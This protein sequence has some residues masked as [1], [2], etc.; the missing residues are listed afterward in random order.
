MINI[1]SIKGLV[2]LNTS[3]VTDMNEM[4][5]DCAK[6]KDLNLVYF[7]THKVTTMDNSQL[8]DAF[9]G[10]NFDVLLRNNI[11]WH[12][13]W[14]HALCLPFTRKKVFSHPLPLTSYHSPLRIH[15]SPISI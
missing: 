1:E 3:E 4:F 13:G 7:D 12:D 11:I 10:M 6:L 5:F 8:L 9:N 2:Y 14:W 15:H